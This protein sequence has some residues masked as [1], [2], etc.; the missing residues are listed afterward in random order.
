MGQCCGCFSRKISL[1]SAKSDNNFLVGS[2]LVRRENVVLREIDEIL[3]ILN[4]TALIFFSQKN[5]LESNF[6]YTESLLYAK[7]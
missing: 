6:Y 5:S 2:D 3:N 7:L 4:K 1:N